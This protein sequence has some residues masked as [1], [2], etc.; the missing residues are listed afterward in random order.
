LTKAILQEHVERN[1][2]AYVDDIVVASRKKETRIQDLAETFTNMRIAQLRLNHEKCVFGVCRGRVLGC[3]VSVKGIEAN[4]YKINAKIHMKPPGSRKE[5]Q[6]LTGRV[7]ELNQF[8]A[9][10]A[11]QSLP[12]FKVLRGTVTFEWAQNSTKPSMH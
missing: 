4:P 7:L 5:V 6:R 3:L 1:V 12:F 9:K 11:K 2:F 8:M 10:L